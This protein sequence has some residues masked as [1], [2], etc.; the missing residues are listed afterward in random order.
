VARSYADEAPFA[1]RGTV[2]KVVF[3]AAPHLDE[4]DEL[5]LH[6]HAHQARTARGINA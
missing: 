4:R 3:D 1:F 2:K 5:A 6:A